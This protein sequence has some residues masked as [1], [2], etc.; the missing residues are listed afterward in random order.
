M[1]QYIS[2]GDLWQYLYGIKSPKTK[3][4]G[5]PLSD[6]VFYATNILSALTYLHDQDIAFRDLKIENF[7]LGYS[8]THLLI[9]SL[10]HSPTYSLTHSLTHSLTYLQIKPDI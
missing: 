8:L 6:A 5:L 10:T 1:Q 7:V 3:L 9:H 2:G 4:G